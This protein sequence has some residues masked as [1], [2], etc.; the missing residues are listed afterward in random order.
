MILVVARGY[1]I[2]SA[3]IASTVHDTFHA[4]T[5]RLRFGMIAFRPR[6]KRQNPRSRLS[7][8]NQPIT[9]GALGAFTRGVCSPRTAQ[10]CRRSGLLRM[11]VM[12]L[13]LRDKFR[14]QLFPPEETIPLTAPWVQQISLP[15]YPRILNRCLKLYS[16]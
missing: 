14:R 4:F 2:I 10:E 9:S 16:A 13:Q 5:M 3:K 8:K 1:D 12:E 7:D 15:R 11:S 6:G